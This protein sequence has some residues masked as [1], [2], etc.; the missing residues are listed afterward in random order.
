MTMASVR[1]L[2]SLLALFAGVAAEARDFRSSDVYPFEYPSVQGVAEMDRLIR[3]R[4]KSRL[5]IEPLGY[6]D[7]SSESYTVAQVRAGTLD[8]ARINLVALNR[9]VPVSVVPALPFL[10]KSSGHLRHILDGPIGAEILAALEAQGLVGLCFYD[11]GPRSLYSVKRLIHKVADLKGVKVRVQQSDAWAM[12]LRALGAEPVAI[13]LDRVQA[14]LQ[15]GVVDAADGDWSSYVATGHYRIAR[16]FSVTEHS[17]SPGVVIFSKRVWDDLSMED[18]TIIRGAAKDSVAYMRK[19]WDESE[20]AAHTI[21]EAAG[22]D[23]I[24]DVDRKSFSDALV[25][26]YPTVLD[27]PKARAMV[28]RIQIDH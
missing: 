24:T 13:P 20:A 2:Y 15:I 27:S 4:S 21:A 22:V 26:L 14:A 17:M 25:P 23:I 12:M 1:V 16:H 28:S 11:A 9:T 8:M 7:R 6:D 10:F 5:A 18:Q 19:L 3:Q